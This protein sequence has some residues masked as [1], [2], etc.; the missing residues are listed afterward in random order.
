MRARQVWEQVGHL[1]ETHGVSYF[2][3]TGDDFMV[4]SYPKALLA[5]R[6]TG[7]SDIRWRIYAY[8]AGLTEEGVATLSLLNVRTV[9]MGVESITSQALRR[10]GRRGYGGGEIEK[11]VARA[12]AAGLRLITSFIFGLEGETVDSTARNRDFI[13]RLATTYPDVF[14][15]ISIRPDGVFSGQPDVYW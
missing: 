13:A 3:E 12:R 1:H 5:R 6:P 7:L 9:F 15:A 8:P 11:I 4:G 2:F 14:E 10:A